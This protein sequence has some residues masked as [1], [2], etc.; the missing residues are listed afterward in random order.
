MGV[1]AFAPQLAVEGFDE[2]IVSRLARPGEVKRHAPLVGPRI[3]VAGD[4]FAAIL[5][6]DRLWIAS[7]AAGLFQR[8]NHVLTT[9]T[10]PRERAAIRS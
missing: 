1:Q 5:D 2:R 4:K 3:H 9:I 10:E 6:S 8:G 7:H